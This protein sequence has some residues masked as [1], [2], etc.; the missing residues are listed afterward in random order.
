M[1]YDSLS[2]VPSCSVVPSFALSW[3][4]L[5]NFYSLFHFLRSMHLSLSL[6]CPSLPDHFLSPSF[7]Y[8]RGSRRVH[9]TAGYAIKA[10]VWRKFMVPVIGLKLFIFIWARFV[11]LSFLAISGPDAWVKRH[12][13]VFTHCG[14]L[15]LFHLSHPGKQISLHFHFSASPP[16]PFFFANMRCFMQC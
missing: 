12:M 10:I 16:F 8:F 6:S 13:I 5:P 11:S 1:R 15:W 3:T 2:P 7:L 14:N 9:S 4:R